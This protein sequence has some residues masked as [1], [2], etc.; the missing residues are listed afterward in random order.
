[1]KKQLLISTALLTLCATATAESLSEINGNLLRTDNEPLIWGTM[2]GSKFWTS[3]QDREADLGLYNFYATDK[4][5]LNPV[6]KGADFSWE[7][8]MYVNGKV[9]AMTNDM[10]D[11]YPSGNRYLA[12]DAETWEQIQ[13]PVVIELLENLAG[14][15]CYDP[16]TGKTYG[17]FAD[18][19]SGV[20][21]NYREFDPNTGVSTPIMDYL[22]ITFPV[23]AINSKGK[24][25]AIDARGDLYEIEKTTCEMT[26]IGYT[27]LD[28]KYSQSMTFD[29]RTDKLY[30]YAS[31]RPGVMDIFEVNVETGE[32]TRI[33]EDG[34]YQM[35]ATFIENPVYGA[36]NW[37]EN[38]A[39][40]ATDN[41][42]LE[43]TLSFKLPEKT[44]D[45]QTLT[46][47][48]E[49]QVSVDGKNV[50]TE[51]GY[52]PGADFEKSLTLTEGQK[53]IAIVVKNDVGKGLFA[54]F[55]VW[56]GTDIPKPVSNLTIADNGGKA[57]LSWEAP[58][59]GVN[60]GNIDIENLRY[61]IVRNDGVTVADNLAECSYTDEKAGEEYAYTFYTVT[62]YN[63]AGES[64]ATVSKAMLFGNTLSTPFTESFANGTAAYSWYE[65]NLSNNAVCWSVE[66]GGNNPTTE[67]FDTDNGLLTFNS[68]SADVPKLTESRIISP[69]IQLTAGKEQYLS[70]ALYHYSGTFTTND[71]VAVEVVKADGS[72]GNLGEISRESAENGWKQYSFDLNKYAGEKAIAIAFKGVSDYGY[73]IHI[74]KVEINETSGVESVENGNIKISAANGTV[75]VTADEKVTVRIYNT[76]GQLIAEKEGTEMQFN[77]QSGIY[78]IQSKNFI[79]KVTVR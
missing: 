3:D 55:T 52:A 29:Y 73:N 69:A 47:D 57:A 15:L 30:W 20:Y 9:Y 75:Y 14:S 23:A 8:A 21:R 2:A 43:G 70:F 65:S 77:L 37:V 17:F 10:E 27:G 76:L 16:T 41:S 61:K 36:P 18:P 5:A 19:W 63:S 79:K 7:S 44:F 50:I 54:R 13:E 25:Y 56:A 38:V 6:V 12:F 24:M 72:V 48:L 33:S 34:P 78:I 67:A 62:A 60:N 68:Y 46:G 51:G 71:K 1:M 53:R 32:A 35:V 28:P 49:V 74:D 42:A 58:E 45:G 11:G 66:S 26:R 40:V 31:T 59:S 22:E 4:V 64:E 39:Y